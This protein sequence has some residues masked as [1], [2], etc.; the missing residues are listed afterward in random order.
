M[1]TTTNIS[2]NGRNYGMIITDSGCITVAG[3]GAVRLFIVKADEQATMIQ[4]GVK[5]PSGPVYLEHEAYSTILRMQ[6]QGE[7]S[8][9]DRVVVDHKSQQEAQAQ[10]DK[11]AS[12][13]K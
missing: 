2:V 10:F 7:S 9:S 5:V 13:V 4:D 8:W 11:M 3:T 12:Q 1:E 6:R